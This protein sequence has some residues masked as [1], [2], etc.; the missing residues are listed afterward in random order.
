M[1]VRA[2]AHPDFVRL[3]FDWTAP[4]D[5]AVSRDGLALTV[6]FD[7]TVDVAFDQIRTN[8]PQYVRGATVG[9]DG[10]SVQFQLAAP[11][12]FCHFV[13][14]GSVVVDLI[15]ES[16]PAAAQPPDPRPDPPDGRRVGVRVGTHSRFTRIVFDWPGTVDYVVEQRGGVILARFALPASFDLSEVQAR[17]PRGIRRIASRRVNSG[18]AVEVDVGGGT[19]V[20][21]FRDGF[22]VVLN[23]LLLTA[24][25]ERPSAPP[26][27]LAPVPASAPI[28][29]VRV[30]APPQGAPAPASTPAAAA[31][32]PATAAAQS[33]PGALSRPQLARAPLAENPAIT[34]DRLAVRQ[35]REP[36]GV[37]LLFPFVD[38]VGAAVFRRGGFLWIVFD[39]LVN[40]DMSRLADTGYDVIGKVEQLNHPSAT[41]LR[42]VT[43]PGVNP[44]VGRDGTNWIVAL[45]PSLLR[46]TAPLDVNVVPDGLGGHRLVLPVERVGESMVIRDPEVGDVLT[47]LPTILLGYGVVGERRFVEFRLLPTAQGIVVAATTDRLQIQS[48]GDSVVINVTGGLQVTAVADRSRLSGSGMTA[49]S[50]P[51]LFAFD[52]WQRGEIGDFDSARRQLLARV[53][54]RAGDERNLARL[55]LARFYFAHAFPEHALGV[56]DAVARDAPGLVRDRAFLSLRGAARYLMGDIEG[57][58]A[59]LTDRSLDGQAEAELWRAALAAADGKWDE[60]VGGYRLARAFVEQYPD[61]IHRRF[62][63]LGAEI[64]LQ[65][66]R[67]GEAR[68]WLKL[69]SRSRLSSAEQSQV[70]LLEGRIALGEGNIEEATQK[71]DLAVES[72]DYRAVPFAMLERAELQLAND[73]IEPQEMIDVLDRLRFL[74]RGDDFE[75]DVLQRLG[76][77]YMEAGEYRSGL[78]TL[79]Q[80]AAAF[81]DH[82]RVGELTELMQRRFRDLYLSSEADALPAVSAIALFNEFRELTPLD[83]SG[84]EMIRRLADRLVAVDLLR[85]ADALLAHQ[86]RF[87][88]K[89]NAERAVVGTRK[90]VVRLLDNRPDEALLALQDT[91]SAAVS[92][93]LRHERRLLEARAHAEFGDMAAAL[94]TLGDDLTPA[95][96]Q[97]RME[98]L[99]QAQ[100]WK[101]VADVLQR[102]AGPPP[103]AG[104][105]LGADRSSYALNLAIAL[106]L[107]GEHERLGQVRR[108]FGPAMTS[109]QYAHDFR[110]IAS[111]ETPTTDL[112]ALLQ[113]AA[114]V[115]DFQAFMA[116]YRERLAAAGRAPPPL[117]N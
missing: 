59:D 3:V 51:R 83:A 81:P 71:F 86:V 111:D 47:V 35:L 31:A 10:R 78:Q 45:R 101:R 68:D 21:H 17:L 113:R 63:L 100:D 102:L 112:D 48:R 12:D 56:M 13:L 65:A 57:A 54:T 1:A 67:H 82:P 52:R 19:R 25:A 108:D 85:Q 37:R 4:V 26:S 95:A 55:E 7:R 34:A 15:G 87:R 29:S 69:L 89:D 76:E 53:A 20:R 40:A 28:R 49:D 38:P 105:S 114:I 117:V 93:P 62:S 107:A 116:S 103:G 16:R 115:D 88:L 110:F 64:A 66:N 11:Y 30:T 41:V 90:A 96:D 46:P 94:R 70:T 2:W 60:A 75:F 14:N 72:G 58:V 23:V 77:I 97:L 27:A 44:V 43:V 91:A 98:I 92:E 22:K 109:S 36:G 32:P 73:E 61:L 8:I 74:W 6:S 18:A 50:V 39:R 24:A 33:A 104:G 106:A 5:Y 9:G 42:L 79:R 99:W 84:D 80:A